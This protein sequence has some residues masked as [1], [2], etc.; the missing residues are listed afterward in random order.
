ML[1]IQVD[2]LTVYNGN[3]QGVCSPEKCVLIN[4][5]I[6]SKNLDLMTGNETKISKNMKVENSD[7]ILARLTPKGYN[8]S[9]TPRPGKSQGGGLIVVSENNITLTASGL[10]RKKA[11]EAQVSDITLDIKSAQ[12]HLRLVNVYRHG[13]RPKNKF[14]KHFE[15]LIESAKTWKCD[16]YLFCG[17]FNLPGRKKNQIYENFETLLKKHGLCQLVK[18]P[19]RTQKNNNGKKMSNLLDLVPD[20]INY[21]PLVNSYTLYSIQLVI[22]KVAQVTKGTAWFTK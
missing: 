2:E 21:F 10:P 9:H 18:K 8:K 6:T 19:T 1:F 11:Y 20:R 17:D 5:F 7:A 12:F 14:R 3:L 15:K 13:G 22:F 4:K 16:G